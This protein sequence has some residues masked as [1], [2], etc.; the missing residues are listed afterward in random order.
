MQR[1][2]AILEVFLTNTV[3]AYEFS[4]LTSLVNDVYDN[5][6]WVEELKTKGSIPHAFYP[7]DLSR[8]YIQKADIGTPNVVEFIGIAEHLIDTIN[9]LAENYNTMLT[10][11]SAA[12][13]TVEKAN[14]IL[15]FMQ[16]VKKAIR[17]NGSADTG[18]ERI[19]LTRGRSLEAELQELKDSQQLGSEIQEEKIDFMNYVRN[20]SF[21][22]ENII[23]NTNITIVKSKS[24]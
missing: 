10:V 3:P 23:E 6:L 12:L 20:I 14:N 16:N 2:Y 7:D 15:G 19:V 22:T 24:A 11:G 13:L 17:R 1:D 21:G 4:R 18:S 5:F 9:F 8:L